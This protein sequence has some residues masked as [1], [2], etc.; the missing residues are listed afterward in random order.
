MAEEIDFKVRDEGTVWI[1]YP[2]TERAKN[3]TDTD[4]GLESW[5]RWPGPSFVVDHRPASDLVGALEDEG[6][7]LAPATD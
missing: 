7:V 2:L 4:L 6:F 3:F 5:Q 1:F